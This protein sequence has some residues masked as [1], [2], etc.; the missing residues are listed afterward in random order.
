MEQGG[1]RARLR[2]PSGPAEGDLREAV[3]RRGHGSEELETVDLMQFQK[4]LEFRHEK[5]LEKH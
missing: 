3:A 2:V 4:R 1:R 5:M